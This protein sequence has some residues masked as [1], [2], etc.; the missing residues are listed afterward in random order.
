MVLLITFSSRWNGCPKDKKR[1][2][3]L[4]RGGKTV[5][6][7]LERMHLSPAK[8]IMETTTPSKLGTPSRIRVFHSESN[9]MPSSPKLHTPQ[10]I[11]SAS[12]PC[13]ER[14]EMEHSH[15]SK[16]TLSAVKASPRQKK[17]LGSDTI[18]SP[19]RYSTRLQQKR[20]GSVATPDSNKVKQYLEQSGYT[21]A[22]NKFVQEG[23]HLES[24]KTNNIGNKK[25]EILETSKP[26]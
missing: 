24:S 4:K 7:Q 13:E 26:R 23:F 22:P 6:K 25:E 9:Y 12:K 11:P 19:V 15:G 17:Q 3:I 18:L 20:E 16:V 21:Y 2:E 5:T 14:T 8:R 1:K 10:R